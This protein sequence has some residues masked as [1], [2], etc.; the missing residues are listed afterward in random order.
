[1]SPTPIL[2]VLTGRAV[3]LGDTGNLSGIAK[4]RRTGPVQ[5]GIAGL[6]DDEHG[7]LAH[8]G[9]P[10]KAI[11]HYP[12]DHYTRW[13][14]EIDPPGA[15]L[16]SPGAFGENISTLGVTE[17]DVCLGDVYRLGSAIVQ[18]SQGRQPC[19]RLNHRFGQPAMAREVQSNG[20]TGWYYR[21]RQIGEVAA[22]DDLALL[23]RPC[24]AWP[25]SRVIALL[26]RN[27]LD[28]E[29]LRGL[30]ELPYCPPGWRKLIERRLATGE[31]ERWEKRLT[32]AE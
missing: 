14:A 8:H 6:A 24:P 2:A 9:G 11:H 7:D 16:A 1:M 3:P 13:S 27:T 18:L 30:L 20:R 15:L 17:R 21:V 31:V 28:P 26:Y 12:Y 32:G 23:E 29:G 10:E 4:H 5:I 25:L 22:G 19:W